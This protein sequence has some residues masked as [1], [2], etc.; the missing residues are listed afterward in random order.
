MKIRS[1]ICQIGSGV[2][3]RSWPIYEIR[4]LCRK[5]S[6]N[7]ACMNSGQTP[8]GHPSDCGC[9]RVGM[10]AFFFF[11]LSFSNTDWPTVR[12][13]HRCWTRPL[14]VSAPA[15]T[16]SGRR[17]P[18]RLA[19]RPPPCVAPPPPLAR[20]RRPPPYGCQGLRCW[21]SADGKEQL[22]GGGRR[23]IKKAACTERFFKTTWR[24]GCL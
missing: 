10:F 18:G 19:C 11:S 21:R 24:S 20:G 6:V 2:E 16:P 23:L 9:Q 14:C 17:G 5:L 13:G 8:R 3:S 4:Y 12:G 15:G 22:I 7:F 1:A